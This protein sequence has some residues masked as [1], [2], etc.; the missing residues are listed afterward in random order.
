MVWARAGPVPSAAIARPRLIR[1]TPAANTRLMRQTPVLNELGQ[2]V[3]AAYYRDMTTLRLVNDCDPRTR[4]VI[5]NPAFTLLGQHRLMT[6]S[7]TI[8]DLESDLTALRAAAERAGTA[9][10]CLFSCSDEFEAEV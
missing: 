9:L 8:A 10:A 1:P 3:A 5:G 4:P 6:P 2:G 7:R